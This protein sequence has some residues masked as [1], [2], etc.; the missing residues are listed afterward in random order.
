MI[1][2]MMDLPQTLLEF[3][4][5]PMKRPGARHLERIRGP[6]GLECPS[7]GLVADPWR[8]R[9]RPRVLECRYCLYE[10]DQ[11]HPNPEKS[12]LPVLTG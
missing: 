12:R 4:Q 2:R 6:E 3:Q 9:A 10:G 7:C 1:R 5:H 8:L 11:A